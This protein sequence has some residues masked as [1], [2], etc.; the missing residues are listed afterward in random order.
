M[1]PEA[2]FAGLAVNELAWDATSVAFVETRSAAA[3]S[4]PSDPT[5][6]DATA[7]RAL[8]NAASGL[9]F[10]LQ[11]STATLGAYLVGF[12]S[13]SLPEA[14]DFSGLGNIER[15]SDVS[16][17]CLD[18][19]KTLSSAGLSGLTEVAH[20]FL[21]KCSALTALDLSACTRLRV[22][23]NGFVN[24]N[25]QLADIN[26]SGLGAVESIGANFLSGNA[27]LQ[28]AT[29]PPMPM[30]QRIEDG[31]MGGTG[32]RHFDAAGLHRVRGIG[33]CFFNGCPHL[34]SVDL[35]GMA[36]LTEIEFRAFFGCNSL[37]GIDMAGLSEL[38]TIGTLFAC[39]CESLTRV[40]TAGLATL[41]TVGD[42][43][44]AQCPALEH[45]DLDGLSTARSVGEDFVN[46]LARGAGLKHPGCSAIV[47]KALPPQALMM[48]DECSSDRGSSSDDE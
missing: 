30:L 38:R 9:W 29:L 20:S 27:K 7:I 12:P 47:R 41:Q 23:G 45:V 33:P 3:S 28:A 24:G 19:V 10:K 8:G 2:H 46:M 1:L 35:R 34:E 5:R 40:S 42:F 37:K 32:I 22:I 36:A 31:W 15:L 18:G 39:G 16:V 14:W 13:V 25:P 48:V 44:L 17:G 26:L 21:F 6:L 43:F 11:P 4:S